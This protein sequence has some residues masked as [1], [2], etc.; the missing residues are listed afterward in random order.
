MKKDELIKSFEKIEPDDFTEDKMLRNILSLSRKRNKRS[1]NLKR[2]VPVFAAAL[3]I[4]GSLLTYN[5]LPG[6]ENRNNRVNGRGDFTEDAVAPITNQ[7]QM[8]NKDYIIMPEELRE[9]YGLPV[10]TAAGDLG[11]RIARIENSPDK[12]LIGSDVYA[13]IPAGCDAVVAVKQDG[14]YKLY[15]FL[16]FEKYNN[17]QDEDAAEY[18]RLYGI[19]TAADISKIQFLG[20]SEQSKQEGIADIRGEITDQAEIEEFYG[21]YGVLKNSS[22]KYFEKLFGYKDNTGENK[23]IVED[24]PPDYNGGSRTPRTE[25]SYRDGGNNAIDLPAYEHPKAGRDMSQTHGDSPV[26]SIPEDRSS[27][28]APAG[29][30]DMGDTVSPGQGSAAG[31]LS[32]SVTIRIYNQ[33]GIFYDAEYYV[34]IGFISRHEIGEDFAEFLR[35][36]I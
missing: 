18:L 27:G 30:M 25:P 20:H 13:Y 17:N 2:A 4:A 21:F 5:L 24:L 29:M 35:N 10:E 36:Y 1:L 33:K 6:A 31:A 3:V 28:G 14:G 32:G 9:K 11:E 19:N 7:F 8:G 12:S 26:Q 34:N 22:D 15:K 16:S 23:G